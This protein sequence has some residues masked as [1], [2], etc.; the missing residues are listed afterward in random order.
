MCEQ[1]MG[2]MARRMQVALMS[3]S[4]PNPSMSA[5]GRLRYASLL[6]IVCCLQAVVGVV[7]RND[8]LRLLRGIVRTRRVLA[9]QTGR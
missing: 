4:K 3:K 1:A 7:G 9:E 8:D 5:R 6:A 2:A